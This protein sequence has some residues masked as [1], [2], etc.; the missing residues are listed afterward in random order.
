MNQDLKVYL[1]LL[2][3]LKPYGGY[4]LLVLIGFALS[5]STEVSIAKL[6]EF[7]INAI[8]TQNT[9]QT[10]L[11]PFLVV[12]LIFVRG[13]GSFLGDYYSA[14]ISRHLVFRCVSRYLQSYCAYPQITI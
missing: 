6:L 4:A 11:F 5:A 2:T 12:L 8:Q 13:V 7:V 14:V 3:Y 10:A 1:R 9:Q